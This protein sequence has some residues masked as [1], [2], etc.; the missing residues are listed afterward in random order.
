MC[1]EFV[2]ESASRA[3]TERMCHLRSHKFL[4]GLHVFHR[5][6]DRSLCRK[7]LLTICR[8]PAQEIL[9]IQKEHLLAKMFV[10]MLLE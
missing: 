3:P 4:Q 9:R 8:C 6:D 2:S 5:S 10:C 7:D 1:S